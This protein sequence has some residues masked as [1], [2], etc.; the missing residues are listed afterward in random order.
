MLCGL[1][2][3]VGAIDGIYISISKPQVGHEYYLYLEFHSYIL[4]GQDVIDSRK[5]LFEGMLGSTNDVRVL[6]QSTLY[7]L[8]TA[9]TLFDVSLGRE[10]FSPNILGD[11]G[12]PLVP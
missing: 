12:Y 9:C 7:Q 5:D 4:N 3:I 10:D 11:S 1:L 6:R 2:A 8:A